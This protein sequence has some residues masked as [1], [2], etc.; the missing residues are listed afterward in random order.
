MNAAALA[1]GSIKGGHE[2]ARKSLYEF[3]RAISKSADALNPTQVWSSPFKNNLLGWSPSHV[4]MNFLSQI[5]SP[6]QL[7]PFN[8]SPLQEIIRKHI[9]FEVLY[10]TK[11]IKLFIGA[12][13][14]ET[15]TLKVFHNDELCEEA[16]LA[17]ACLPTISQAV[18][19]KGRYYW[20]GGYIGNPALESLI[21]NC[22]SKDIIIVPINAIC[23]RGVPKTPKEILDRQNE[24]TFN[25]TL[26]REIRSILQIQALSKHLSS[27]N[28]FADIRLHSIQNE[29]FMKTLGADSKF[30]TDWSFLCEVKEVG[31]EAADQWIKKSYPLVGK[32][33]TMDLG[34]WRMDEP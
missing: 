22:V 20:D 11:K 18:K 31:R 34:L 6:Y 1:C 27:E 32:E 33:T 19:W 26:M 9:D 21:Y 30:N 17:S 25:T 5:L 23:H 8:Y 13:N 3:W 16:L 14:V 15:N 29:E 7:N 2:G 4:W 12:T 24:V 10:N 28:P